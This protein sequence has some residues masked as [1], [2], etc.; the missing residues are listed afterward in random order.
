MF[1]VVL[2]ASF[3]VESIYFRGFF[4]NEEQMDIIVNFYPDEEQPLFNI[5]LRK[6][7]QGDYLQALHFINA[8]IEKNKTNPWKSFLVQARLDKARLLLYVDRPEEGRK[9]LEQILKT[10]PET[11]HRFQAYLR[12]S[13]YYE[14]KTDYTA[15]L[16]MLR[17]AEIL[18]RTP[19][20]FYRFAYVLSRMNKR[21]EALEIIKKAGDTGMKTP[22]LEQLEAEIRLQSAR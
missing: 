22:Q 1:L 18:G 10:S 16:H 7:R 11:S 8:A 20:L 9:L 13:E 17:E 15:A 5:A 21:R 2:G 4:K 6:A 3:A 14:L 12:L 19:Y